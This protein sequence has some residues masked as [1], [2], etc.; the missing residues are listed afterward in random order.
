MK[1]FNKRV[2]QDEQKRLSGEETWTSHLEREKERE[3]ESERERERERERGRREGEGRGRVRE[4]EQ[5]R[6]LTKAQEMRGKCNRQGGRKT[7]GSRPVGRLSPITSSVST[8]T[9]PNTNFHLYPTA[10]NS[11]APLP[12]TQL[13]DNLL[14]PSDN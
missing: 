3:R 5:H 14:M 4:E 11:S 12:S 2:E 6:V 7:G 10:S 1:A 13:P 8:F 9:P